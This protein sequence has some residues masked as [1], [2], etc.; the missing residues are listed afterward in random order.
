MST[1][2]PGDFTLIGNLTMDP[3]CMLICSNLLCE[4]SVTIINSVL[5]I[6]K[7]IMKKVTLRSR[8]L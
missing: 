6:S 8:K 4:K 3:F 5:S 1:A 2:I 7:I